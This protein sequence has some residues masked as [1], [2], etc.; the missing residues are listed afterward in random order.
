[1]RCPDDLIRLLHSHYDHYK[2]E[3][4]GPQ[5][6]CSVAWETHT[7]KKNISVFC[8]FN[9]SCVWHCSIHSQP[10][11]LQ[12]C[13]TKCSRWN[14][15]SLARPP[16]GITRGTVAKWFLQ[17]SWLSQTRLPWRTSCGWFRTSH[18]SLDGFQLKPWL[19]MVKSFW[20]QIPTWCLNRYVSKWGFLFGPPNC[21]FEERKGHLIL[22]HPE[23]LWHP[24]SGLHEESIE[25]GH[26]KS[27]GLDIQ[28]SSLLDL[29]S[30]SLLCSNEIQHIWVGGLMILRPWS[31]N[32]SVEWRCS[33]VVIRQLLLVAV[34]SGENGICISWYRAWAAWQA[35]WA[36][37]SWFECQ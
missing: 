23:I 14:S 10:A 26:Y 19:F 6:L 12:G 18:L 21:C 29:C 4:S 25:G 3:N 27:K 17:R 36:G 22:K 8:D 2:A 5:I 34:D 9:V 20:F 31:E 11:C 28:K 37:A 35:L 33:A 32:A 24:A 30:N 15:L 16:E 1:M 7:P 13:L